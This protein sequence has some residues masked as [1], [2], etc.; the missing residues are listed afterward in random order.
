MIA[1]DWQDV[2]FEIRDLLR[3]E[4]RGQKK[5]YEEATIHRVNG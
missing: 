2:I 4:R 3:K 5:R 1:E